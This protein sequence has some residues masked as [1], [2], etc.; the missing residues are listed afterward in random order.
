[1]RHYYSIYSLL[2]FA[3]LVAFSSESS[4]QQLTRRS[5]FVINTYMA[6]PAVAGTMNYTPF[7][8][9]YRNQWA[10]FKGAPVTMMASGHAGLKNGLGYGAIAYHDDTGGAISESGMELTGA[11]RVD[12]NNYDVVSFGLSLNASQYAFDNASLVVYDQNDLALNGGV[13]EKSTNLDAT[14]GFLVYGKQYYAGFSIPQLFESQ[15]GLESEIL[16][17]ENRNRRHFQLMGSYKYYASD[18]WDIQPSVFMRFMGNLPAQM[19][20]NVRAIYNQVA[21]GGLTYRHRDAVALMLGA[22]YREFVFAYSYDLTTSNART[23]SPHTHELTIGYYLPKKSG[24]FRTSS[25]GPRI[26]DRGRVV[27]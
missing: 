8:V 10:G 12:L 7:F 15:L 6:N 26:L 4:A 2:L 22:N 5:Q 3:S 21:F 17:S 13:A 14:F 1:M 27:N 11:Y 16:A 24:K 25:L 20:L 18:S 23:M 9:S 19:D